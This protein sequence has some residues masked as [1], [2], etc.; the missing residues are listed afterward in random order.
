MG[1]GGPVFPR[2]IGGCRKYFQTAGR[3]IH[4]RVDG[5]IGLIDTVQLFGAGVNVNQLLLGPGRLQQGVAGGGHLAQARADGDDHVAG[6]DARCQPRV[7]A[8]TY[9]AGIQRVKVVKGS[10]P[11]S[12][13]YESGP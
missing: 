2:V 4:G 10:I 6:L 1:G 12:I 3:S 11:G 13:Q 9:V 8:N 7:D 5:Q